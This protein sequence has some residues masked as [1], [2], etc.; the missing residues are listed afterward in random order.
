MNI[1]I[2]NRAK[3][4]LY[5]QIVGLDTHLDSHDYYVIA[6]HFPTDEQTQKR[7][8]KLLERVPVRKLILIDH[9]QPGLRG[10]F[11]AAYQDF[12][13]DI[14]DALLRVS[15]TPLQSA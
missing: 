8:V 9:L 5:K 2:D 6:P 12:E 4:S 10:Q 15:T 3:H 14:Y 1:R 11:G 13:N 7:V